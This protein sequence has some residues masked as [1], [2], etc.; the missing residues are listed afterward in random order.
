MVLVL[1]QTRPFDFASAISAAVGLAVVVFVV[2][3]LAVEA[4][5]LAAGGVWA[6][7]A[8]VNVRAAVRA[9]GMSMRF[10]WSMATIVT[11]SAAHLY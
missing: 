7:A 10:V 1:H 8:K 3:V 9:A 4:A 11:R 2:A 5:E 6:M